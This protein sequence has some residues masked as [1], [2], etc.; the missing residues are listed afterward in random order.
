[1]YRVEAKRRRDKLRD[2]YR[3]LK[4]ALPLSNLNLGRATTHIN[5]VEMFLQ[6]LHTRLQKAENGI[7]RLH[8]CVA[9]MTMHLI[10]Y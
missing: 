5:Y 6:Q 1:M 9:S 8:Q 4:D 2:D 7:A 10:L 3:P